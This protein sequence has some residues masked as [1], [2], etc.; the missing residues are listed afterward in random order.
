MDRRLLRFAFPG[1]QALQVIQGTVQTE[2]E[3]MQAITLNGSAEHR[4]AQAIQEEAVS[5]APRVNWLVAGEVFFALVA[6]A[7]M[8]WSLWR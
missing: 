3:A 5:R 6:L 1:S 2:T 4:V 7:A 8:I